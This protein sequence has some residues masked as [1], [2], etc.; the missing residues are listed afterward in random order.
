MNAASVAPEEFIDIPHKPAIVTQ[1]ATTETKSIKRQ[2]EEYFSDIPMLIRVAECESRFTQYDEDGN[3]FRGV[4]P[5]DVGVMQINERYW[6]KTADRLGI[7]LYTTEGNMTYARYLYNKEGL[8]PWK[9][10]SH[11][12]S[13]GIELA[14]AR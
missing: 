6:G 7:N 14:L 12:W 2:V 8:R 1:K 3:V 5:A 13:K 11:C 10:S 9:A 4:V